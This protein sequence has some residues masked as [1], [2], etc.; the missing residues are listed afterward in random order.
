MPTSLPTYDDGQTVREGDAV[1]TTD[2]LEAA[3]VVQFLGPASAPNL[4]VLQPASGRQQAHHVIAGRAS[5][6]LLLGRDGT[7]PEAAALQHLR[8]R[9]D[10]GDGPARFA[11]GSR[12]LL[13]RGV[14]ADKPGGFAL[15][16]QAALGGH[17]E[18]QHMVGTM[19]RDPAQGLRF[20]RLAAEQGH[21]LAQFDLGLAHHLGRRA[22]QD[23]A[24]AAQWYHRAASQGQLAALYNLG[25]AWAKSPQHA[26]RADTGIDW[27]RARAKVGDGVAAWVMGQCATD[28]RHGEPRDAVQAVAWYRI[29]AAAQH[30]PSLCNLADKFEHGLGVR[31]D[32][33]EAVRLYHEAA[34][35]NVVAAQFALGQLF[36]DGRGVRA[37]R[38]RAIQWFTVA[39]HHGWPGA[40][41]ALDALQTGGRP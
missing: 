36:R 16:Q 30:G 37:D 31:Q 27:V 1:M 18:A 24:Q 28:G 2:G 29:G 12:L 9:A 22:E 7:D 3:Q 6:L 11:L 40:Q 41:Q 26:E 15:L 20:W 25:Q 4:V 33:P 35:Q 8:Q 17:A 39:A 5:G 19:T 21:V 14:A 23:Y 32:L 38:A 13:G 10:G 34:Q